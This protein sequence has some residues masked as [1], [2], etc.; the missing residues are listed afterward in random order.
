MLTEDGKHL[1]ISH[2]EYLDLVERLAVCVARSGW[3]FDTV[4][5]LARGGMR[6]GDILSRIFKKPLAIWATGSYRTDAVT[7]RKI[8]DE[9]FIAEHWTLVRAKLD[10]RI[11]LVDDLVDSGRTLS[12]IMKLL[13]EKVPTLAEVRTA[14][15]WTKSRASF[16]PDYLVRALDGNPWIHQPFEHYDRIALQD[17]L[18][19][20]DTDN[21]ELR[22]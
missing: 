22:P 7:A 15:L 16:Q 9:V 21:F 10:G 6:V 1:Y 8:P 2:D 20:D 17:L 4:L 13:K 3:E 19:R 14:V 18:N 11:L 12:A 5:C